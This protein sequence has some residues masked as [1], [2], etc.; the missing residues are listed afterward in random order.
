MTP[1]EELSRKK[2]PKPRRP[3]P[4]VAW[5]CAARGR[6]LALRLTLEDVAAG[7]GL[8]VTAVWHAERGADPMLT[9]ARKLAAFYG[10]T[11]ED[12]WP[13]LAGEVS[14]DEPTE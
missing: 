3:P 12:L 8:S 6:R 1:A 7:A 11:V 13:E 10:V 14:R 5:R 4:R 9:T 2:P